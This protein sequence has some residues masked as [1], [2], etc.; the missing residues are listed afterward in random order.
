MGRIE[1]EIDPITMQTREE[2]WALA[3][4]QYEARINSRP[5]SE[6]QKEIQP[7]PPVKIPPQH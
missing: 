4:E 2:A 6:T 1:V 3:H 5:N 7:K